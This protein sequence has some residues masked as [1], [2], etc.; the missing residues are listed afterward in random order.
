M[1]VTL[2]NMAANR[3]G[4]WNCL[5]I[6][7]SHDNR[8]FLS[9][10]VRLSPEFRKQIVRMKRSMPEAVQGAPVE[11]VLNSPQVAAS[12][13]MSVSPRVDKKQP[14][15]AAYKGGSEDGTDFKAAPVAAVAQLVDSG[16]WVAPLLGS[17]ASSD[18]SAGC[19]LGPRSQSERKASAARKSPRGAVVPVPAHAEACVLALST[20]RRRRESPLPSRRTRRAAPALCSECYMCTFEMVLY[21][22]ICTL[23]VVLK[24]LL[25]LLLLN[26][27]KPC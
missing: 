20:P 26:M 11:S 25:L 3:E 19:W 1:R 24:L 10:Q 21:M 27:Y 5:A 6:Y 2:W 23:L 9:V 7:P 22:Q 8:Y 14:R 16:L 13:R 4:F 17:P 18:G 15:S 12:S